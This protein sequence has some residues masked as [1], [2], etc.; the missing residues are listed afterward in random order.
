MN[1]ENFVPASAFFHLLLL[2]GVFESLT[3]SGS[4][5]HKG[6]CNKIG[7][8]Q[9]NIMKLFIKKNLIVGNLWE[10]GTKRKK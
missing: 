1:T 3:S 10:R 8:L 6:K 4:P 9:Y 5:M 2:L 7:P